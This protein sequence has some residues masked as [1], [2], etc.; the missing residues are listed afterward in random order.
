MRTELSDLDLEAVAAGMTK[1]ARVRPTA[2]EA[3]GS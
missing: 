2:A 1:P 3:G